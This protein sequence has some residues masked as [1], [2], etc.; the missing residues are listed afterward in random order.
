L[1]PRLPQG[2]LDGV[3]EVSVP[4]KPSDIRLIVVD[5]DAA[6]RRTVRELLGGL[7]YTVVAEARDGEEARAAAARAGADAAVVDVH[8]PDCDGF[9]LAKDLRAL[10]LRVLLTS[11]DAT[12]AMPDALA[13]CGAAGFVPKTQL[14]VTDLRHYLSG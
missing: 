11:S 5:D 8:L 1:P 3:Q 12:V 4:A 9:A 14:A 7:G 2:I 13:Q 6:F 10:E